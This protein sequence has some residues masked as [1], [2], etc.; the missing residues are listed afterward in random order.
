MTGCFAKRLARFL[1]FGKKRVFMNQRIDV[2]VI[3]SGTRANI[4]EKSK[5]QG[6][7]QR[8]AVGQNTHLNMRR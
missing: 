3:G 1:H 7:E 2:A 5:R 4:P 8:N 6:D